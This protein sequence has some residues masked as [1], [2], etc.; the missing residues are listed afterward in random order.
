MSE[1][2]TMGEMLVEIMRTELDVELNEAGNFRGP[3]PSGAPAIFI[4][5]VARLGHSAAL[6]GGVGKDAFGNCLINRLEKDGVDCSQVLVS[7]TGTTG[8]AF[9]SYLSDGSRKFIY[10]IGDTPAVEAKAPT[11]DKLKGIKYFHIMG[12][13]LMADVQFAGEIRKLMHTAR[14]LGAK[15]SFDPNIRPELL[16]D[17]S[18]QGIV[19]EVF[20]N[21]NILMPGIEELLMLTGEETI[22]KAVKKC[23]SN[24][25]I[26]M[27]VLKRGSKGS[28]VFTRTETDEIGV[29]PIVP[30][31]PTGAGDSFDGAFLCGLIEGKSIA[32]VLE[33]ATS[34]ASLNTAAFGPME[35][36]ISVA[37]VH[38]LIRKS[39]AK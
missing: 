2:W 10:H 36:D 1:V 39:T 35:G 25:K 28:S 27:I 22:A 8:V 23:F 12:C 30:V 5:T 37:T 21:T 18:L 29:Y 7:E 38:D 6:V 15:I 14:S 33:I 34:A 24:P 26:E 4:D 19:N 9:V 13:S 11:A 16:G 3:F 17:A 31:D 20:E 32:E